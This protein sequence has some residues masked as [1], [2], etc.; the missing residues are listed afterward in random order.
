MEAGRA[1]VPDAPGK[2]VP[3]KLSFAEQQKRLVAYLF[4]PLVALRRIASVVEITRATHQEL[5]SAIELLILLS[6]SG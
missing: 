6:L 3:A 4:K 1:G 5:L 2:P